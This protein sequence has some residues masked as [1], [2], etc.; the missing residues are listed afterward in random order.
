MGGECYY[1]CI[2]VLY[3]DLIK[4]GKG[5]KNMF[6]KYKCVIIFGLM[7][8]EEEENYCVNFLYIL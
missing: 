3:I 5:E 4:G 2:L 1:Y 7:K 6:C 8:N